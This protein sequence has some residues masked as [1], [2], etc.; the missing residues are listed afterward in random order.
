MDYDYKLF[1]IARHGDQR[2]GPYPYAYHLA[3]VEAKL[4]SLINEDDQDFGM[5]DAC[6]EDEWLAAAWLHDIVE[7]TPTTIKE[8]EA[9]FGITVANLVWAVTGVGKNRKE[10]FQ[11]I[12]EKINKYPLAA[13]LKLA[14]RIANVKFSL[15]A[16][17][18]QLNVYKEEQEAFEALIRP[19]VLEQHW[20]DLADLFDA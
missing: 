3:S 20:K 1:A 14:D 10:R 12:V 7:D 16:G 6:T 19:K 11:S 8:V 18:N 2:Y 15:T 9:D 5:L 17:A 13:T 4:Q